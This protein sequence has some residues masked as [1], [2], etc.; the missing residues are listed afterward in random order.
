MASIFAASATLSQE[1]RQ[2]RVRRQLLDEA[3]SKFGEA[4]FLQL[5]RDRLVNIC[6]WLSA[7]RLEQAIPKL[8]STFGQA[9]DPVK[10]VA[11]VFKVLGDV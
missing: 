1:Q 2:Y 11:W 5:N 6:F 4:V 3:R 8:N 7:G 10:F 9:I